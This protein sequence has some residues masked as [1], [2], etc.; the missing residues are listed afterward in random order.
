MAAIEAISLS[1]STSDLPATVPLIGI[2]I[3]GVDS[4][5]IA[6]AVA[7][8]FKSIPGLISINKS[9]SRLTLASQRCHEPAL[10][11]A[12]SPRRASSLTSQQSCCCDLKQMDKRV[13]SCSLLRL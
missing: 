8:A 11:F 12:R 6:L 1:D 7:K 3:A 13:T 9:R 2:A 4:E 10:L 5:K